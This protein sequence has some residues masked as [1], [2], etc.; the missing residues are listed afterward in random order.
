MNEIRRKR[1]KPKQSINIGE[2]TNTIEDTKIEEQKLKTEEIDQ[3]VNTKDHPKPTNNY[4]I[5]ELKRMHLNEV[6]KMKSQQ[7][8]ERRAH[9]KEKEKLLMQRIEIENELEEYKSKDKHTELQIISYDENWNIFKI[10]LIVIIYT[11]M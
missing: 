7:K 9:E 6:E 2:I 5:E 4:E 8:N 11:F 1:E 3:N 10:N